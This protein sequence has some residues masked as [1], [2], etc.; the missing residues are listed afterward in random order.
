MATIYAHVT[1]TRTIHT[2]DEDDEPI[3]QYGWID[4]WWSRTELLESRN[5]APPVVHCAEDEPD[6]ADHVRDALASH[7]PGPVH[8]NGEG[9]FYAGADHTPTDDEG[10]YTYALHFTRKDFHPGTGWTESSWCPIDDGH[11]DLG[12]DLAP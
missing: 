12:K 6:L 5:D 8:N 11:L 3:Y 4:P 2:S 7:L 9:T 1:C 10:S